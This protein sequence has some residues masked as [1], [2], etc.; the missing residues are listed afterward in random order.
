MSCGGSMM[1][2]SLAPLANLVDAAAEKWLAVEDTAIAE[3]RI[4]IADITRSFNI[5]D[6]PELSFHGQHY[7]LTIIRRQDENRFDI[8]V[9]ELSYNR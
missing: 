6:W 5:G 3:Q 9:V 2:A 1:R 8:E 4:V 7:V